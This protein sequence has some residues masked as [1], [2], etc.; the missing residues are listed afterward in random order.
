M[1]RSGLWKSNLG[2]KDGLEKEERLPVRNFVMM[3]HIKDSSGLSYSTAA[4]SCEVMMKADLWASCEM[5]GKR[6]VSG[7]SKRLWRRGQ[8]SLQ[9][10]PGHPGTR[11]SARN[12]A[13]SGQPGFWNRLKR[14]H[15]RAK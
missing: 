12:P 10:P 5:R 4:V 3:T 13:A 7:S 14:C 15:H 1:V 11:G 6:T 2:V 9:V 8:T